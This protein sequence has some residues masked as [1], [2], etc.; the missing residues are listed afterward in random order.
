VEAFRTKPVEP[1][2]ARTISFYYVYFGGRNEQFNSGL[3]GTWTNTPRLPV[4]PL[5]HALQPHP[6]FTQPPLLFQ[7]PKCFEGLIKASE[8]L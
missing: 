3:I 2:D 6:V 7:L 1:F 5:G 4:T 8:A